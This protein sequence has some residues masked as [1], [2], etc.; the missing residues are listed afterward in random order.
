MEHEKEQEFFE[1]NKWYAESG[2][3]KALKILENGKKSTQPSEH[4]RDL[5]N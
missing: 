5:C 3:L 4:S 1:K 2:N